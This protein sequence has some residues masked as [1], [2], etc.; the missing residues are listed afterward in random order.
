[1]NEDRTFGDRFLEVVAVFLLAIT[2]LGTAW[3]GYQA[4]KW[5]GVQSDRNQEQ[6]EHRLEA[7]RAFALAIQTFSY[8]SNVIAF[9]AQ[10]VQAG[11]T[12]L[13]QFYRNIMV[14][15]DLLPYLDDWETVVLGGGTP[16]PLLENPQYTG[17]QSSRYRG[18][19]E[20][21]E[22][23]ARAAQQ[24]G[25][26]SQAY[27]LNTIVLAVALF[28][29]GVTSSFRYRPARVLLI[30]LAILTLAFAATRLADLPIA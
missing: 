11:N 26:I 2:T 6:T 28:F 24:A 22:T 4:S 8:D 19:Q 10:A 18:E 29:T 16:T 27:V 25:D 12:G 17:A 15:K 20:A 3:C 30:V 5:S 9:Y 21:A 1:M 23:A 13:A 7:N 14:R